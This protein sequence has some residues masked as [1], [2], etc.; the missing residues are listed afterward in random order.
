M[1]LAK[2]CIRSTFLLDRFE[3]ETAHKAELLQALQWLE[4]L[5]QLCESCFQKYV[6]QQQL[7]VQYVNV[8]R[9]S[10]CCKRS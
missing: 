10:C 7:L 8:R 4:V 2:S 9:T 1:L 6:T 3:V 5:W